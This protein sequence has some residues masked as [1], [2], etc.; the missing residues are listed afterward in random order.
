MAPRN[1]KNLNDATGSYLPLL[2]GTDGCFADRPK[3]SK[4]REVFIEKVSYDVYDCICLIQH[5]I[6]ATARRVKI[7]LILLSAKKVITKLCVFMA[8]SQ[9]W[10]RRVV[11][12]KV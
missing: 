1:P 8:G 3:T 9:V 7:H 6:M 2:N 12:K 5:F 10:L 4:R 11:L